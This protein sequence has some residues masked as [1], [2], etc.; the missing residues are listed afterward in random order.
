VPQEIDSEQYGR[1][2]VRTARDAREMKAAVQAEARSL[3]PNLRLWLNS[4]EEIIAGAK[5]VQSA[6]ITSGLAGGLGLLALLLAMIG[7]YGVMAFAVIQRT[8]EIG[9]RMALGAQAIDVLKM[10]IGWGM[11]LVCIGAA[12]GLV[13]SLAVAQLMRSTLFGLSVADPVT[14]AAVILLLALVALL[15]CW[16][17]AQRA[18]KVDPL[19]AL[20]CE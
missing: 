12:L 17:P 20:R 16:I 4:V 3:A 5:Y 6:R 9:I 10:V 8:R 13:L 7:V 11:R 19:V 1:V 14:F 2:L 15:A 18:T